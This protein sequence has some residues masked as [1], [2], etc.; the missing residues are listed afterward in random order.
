[1]NA[2][3]GWSARCIRGLSDHGN[4]EIPFTSVAPRRRRGE[5]ADRREWD[6]RAPLPAAAAQVAEPIPLH[7]LRA[8]SL[9]TLVAGLGRDLEDRQPEAVGIFGLTDED[10]L[11][12]VVG[13]ERL[14]VAEVAELPKRR[15]VTDLDDR[16]GDALPPADDP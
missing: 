13:R 16:L 9:R 1:M 3:R 8:A 2:R 12:I 4:D 7:A 6:A 15:G 14:R 11:G 10:E 5:L